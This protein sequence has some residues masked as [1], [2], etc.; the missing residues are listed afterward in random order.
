MS[1]DEKN[2]DRPTLLEDDWFALAVA[3]VV[4]G[5]VLFGF[6]AAWIMLTDDLT[7]AKQRTDIVVPFAT[8]YLAVV[9]FFTVAWRGLVSAR[10]ADQQK[11]QNDANDDASYAKLLQE[12]A[13]LLGDFTKAQDQLAGLASL[14][15]VIHE[16]RKRFS[17]Q[18]L[19]VVANFYSSIHK[20]I[21]KTDA[22]N[23]DLNAV[24]SFARSIMNGA[25]SAGMRSSI[26]ASFSANTPDMQ[27]PGVSGFQRQEYYGGRFADTQLEKICRDE[28]K[29]DNAHIW[30][31]EFPYKHAIVTN[32][33]FRWCKVRRLDDI[34]VEFDGNKF[35]NCEFS[36]CNFGSDPGFIDEALSLREAG[37]WFDVDSP[38]SFKDEFD[39]ERILIPKRRKANGVYAAVSAQDDD[40]DI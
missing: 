9:T 7:A 36:G 12:G 38:P 5:L 24:A 17:P 35:E 30:K 4:I 27:W 8:I 14:E 33:V 29:I 25:S 32:C 16:P 6:V 15:V 19:D 18:A 1:N 31:V 11:A 40:L 3:S 37:N 28:F 34:D 2:N 13:K 21:S 22:V 39:W 26:R 10:Q 23:Y 20:G